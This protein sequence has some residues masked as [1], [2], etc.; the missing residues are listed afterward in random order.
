M[1][2][3]AEMELVLRGVNPDGLPSMATEIFSWVVVMLTSEA[4]LSDS[5][6]KVSE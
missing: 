2:A 4:F 5:F 3:P 1:C 6:S